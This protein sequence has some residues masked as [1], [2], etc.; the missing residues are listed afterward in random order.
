M[1]N[2][3][4]CATRDA[5]SQ[6]CHFGQGWRRE[7]QQNWKLDLLDLLEHLCGVYF[8]PCLEI[9]V[10]FVSQNSPLSFSRAKMHLAIWIFI[11][12]H[13]IFAF[14]SL[15]LCIS[16]KMFILF[17]SQHELLAWNDACSNNIHMRH[18]SL[19]ENLAPLHI[20]DKNKIKGSQGRFL[21]IPNAYRKRQTLTRVSI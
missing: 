3:F 10:R 13:F 5:G 7:C 1:L 14:V 12:P 9:F 16:R 21:A 4:N 2:S 17:I 11:C 19:T 8:S 6:S 15:C 20:L 18:N